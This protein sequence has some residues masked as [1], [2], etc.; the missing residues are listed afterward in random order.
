MD[1]KQ[2]RT[3]YHATFKKYCISSTLD[4]SEDD[5]LWNDT[6]DDG[7]RGNESTAKEDSSVDNSDDSSSEYHVLFS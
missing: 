2:K 3:S 1:S 7:E 4:G 6:K 5:V